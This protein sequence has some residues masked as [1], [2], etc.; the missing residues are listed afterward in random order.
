M[1]YLG[2]AECMY[3][4]KRL[5]WLIIKICIK[6]KKYTHECLF[7]PRKKMERRNIFMS[8]KFDA[9]QTKETSVK[10]KIMG[11]SKS[12]VFIILA[13][14]TRCSLQRFRALLKISVD[15]MIKYFKNIFVLILCQGGSV[16]VRNLIFYKDPKYQ[17]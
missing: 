10:T 11:S 8:Q 17:C 13:K 2:K 12:L 4:F 9:K 6:S 14:V 16:M 7:L 1:V 5:T 3:H 15:F